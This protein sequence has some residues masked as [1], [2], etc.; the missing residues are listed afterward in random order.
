MLTLLLLMGEAARLTAR[1][2]GVNT[3]NI[4]LQQDER[5]HTTGQ[6]QLVTDQWSGTVEIRLAD[7][8]LVITGEAPALSSY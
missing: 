7:I 5:L 6:R 4:W 3:A 2:G 1:Q 8:K